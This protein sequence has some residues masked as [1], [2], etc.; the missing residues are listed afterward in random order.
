MEPSKPL[1]L[2]GTSTN[3][4]QTILPALG[5]EDDFIDLVRTVKKK[6]LKTM[7]DRRSDIV[8]FNLK[9]SEELNEI[10]EAV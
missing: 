5:S 7:N 6:D 8:D 3:T 2:S 10:Y 1:N 4:F 9:N